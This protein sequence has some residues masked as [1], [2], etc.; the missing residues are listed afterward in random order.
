MGIADLR[1]SGHLP[2]TSLTPKLD[3]N[4]VDL[5]QARGADWLTVGETATVCI[6]GQAPGNLCGALSQPLLLFTVGA[7]SVLCHM[8]NF[9][10][11][12]G[13]LKLRNV[14][15]LGAYPGQFECG[16]GGSYRR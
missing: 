15:I 1:F 4:L 10:T 16:L 13:I 9:G 12:L 14:N 6:D 8:H 11:H 7:K 2:S 5:P 3:T